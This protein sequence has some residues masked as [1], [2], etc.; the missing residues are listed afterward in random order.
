MDLGWLDK[1]APIIQVNIIDLWDKFISVGD[2]IP[3]ENLIGIAS[4]VR[5]ILRTSGGTKYGYAIWILAKAIVIHG[6]EFPL[7]PKEG[8]LAKFSYQGVS[9]LVRTTPTKYKTVTDCKV[10]PIIERMDKRWY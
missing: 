9:P 6:K 8:I 1:S 4:I 2:E 5:P 3:L 7:D 10:W